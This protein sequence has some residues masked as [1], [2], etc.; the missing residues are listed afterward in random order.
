[1]SATP[2]YQYDFFIVHAS[3]DA[4]AAEALYDEL[5]PQVRVFLDCK[6]LLPGDDWDIKLAR[7]QPASLITS[8]TGFAGD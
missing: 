4:S 5:V 7:A 6:T 3:A 2:H 8:G 1:M